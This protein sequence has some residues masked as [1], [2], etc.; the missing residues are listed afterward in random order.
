MNNYGESG[1][2]SQTSATPT[3]TATTVT[4]IDGNVYNTVTIGTQVWMKENL[5]VTKYRNGDAIPTTTANIFSGES[6]PKYQWAYNNDEN[7]VSTYGRLYTWYAATDSR[8]VCPTG[9]HVPTDAEWT[10]LTDYL[11]GE[12]VAGGK[13][14][15]AGTTHWISPNVGDNSSGFTAL[16][17]GFRV[18]E[19]P[20]IYMGDTGYWW[21]ATEGEWYRYG[22]YRYLRYFN[23]YANRTA[24]HKSYGFSVRCVRD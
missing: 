5:K 7:N 18:S 20:F 3:S 16:P 1:E 23:D 13:M 4:D 21:S 11:R 14:K 19:G 9:W 12:S 2:S 17:G 24:D 6:S 15:E 8:G 22:W 10:T